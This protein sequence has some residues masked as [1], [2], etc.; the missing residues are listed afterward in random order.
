MII[1]F[2]FFY[3]PLLSFMVTNSLLSCILRIRIGEKKMRSLE[4]IV[5][6]LKLTSKFYFEIV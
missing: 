2:A 1:N 3:V 4:W 6:L 5:I